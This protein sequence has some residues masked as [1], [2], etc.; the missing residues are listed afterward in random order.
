MTNNWKKTLLDR[1]SS[2]SE[3]ASKSIKPKGMSEEELYRHRVSSSLKADFYVAALKEAVERYGSPY[4]FNTDQGAQFASTDF[5]NRLKQNDIL[6]GPDGRARYQG[7]ICVER[8]WWTVKYQD[9]PLHVFEGGKD[10][11]M[12]LK[13]WCEFNHQ[14]KPHPAYQG[15]TPDEI[16]HEGLA[17]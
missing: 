8:L 10:L 6:I 2:V 17:G 5:T 13:S 3:M 15:S 16:Y 7:N 11:K 12:G 14:E 9:L 4:I 1:A